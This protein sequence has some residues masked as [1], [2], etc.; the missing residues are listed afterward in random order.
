MSIYTRLTDLFCPG[1]GVTDAE[2]TLKQSRTC[3]GKLEGWISI[4]ANLL[5]GA[6]K[7]FFGTLSGSVALV[8]DAF[9]SFADSTTSIIVVAGFSLAG[10]QPDRQH[11]FGH[12]RA[13]AITTLIIAVLLIVAG[14]EMLRTALLRFN[15]PPAVEL[16]PLIVGVVLCSILVKELLAQFGH[17]L[18]RRINSDALKADAWHHRSDAISSLLVLLAMTLSHYG[19]RY[20]DPLMGG[21]VALMIIWMGVGILKRAANTLVGAPPE[22][23]F[24]Q[25]LLR[26]IR[27]Q[28]EV[29]GIHDIIVNSY[30]PQRIVSFHTEMDQRVSLPQSHVIVEQ[31]IFRL[32][33]RM[34]ITPTVHVD[35]VDLED[36]LTLQVRN[37]LNR[38]LEELFPTFACHDVRL[39]GLAG[40]NPDLELSFDLTLPPETLADPETAP[41]LERL[42]TGLCGEYAVIA[43]VRIQVATFF[44]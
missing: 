2:N 13:E 17:H 16:S 24:L 26:I 44:V 30:G 12:G 35:P 7:L 31:L 34:G 15:Q 1:R 3:I 29:V 38:R 37:T 5:L 33:N 36:P 19:I 11:P 21:I 22:P 6:L 32:Q 20:V 42:K 14:V 8:A 9:H 4:L 18:G 43:R 41:K 40:E 23:E 39:T 28:P 10:K 27:E 25:E